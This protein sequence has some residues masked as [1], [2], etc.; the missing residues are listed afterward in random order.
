M[1]NST[2]GFTLIELLIVIAIIG[3]LAGVLVP[4]AV[5][6]RAKATDSAAA[7]V[8]RQVATAAAAVF[9]SSNS[10]PTCSY[11]KPATLITGGSQSVTVNIAIPVTNIECTKVGTSNA[12]DVT[13]TYDGGTKSSVTTTIE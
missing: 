3:L 7:T 10:F 9:I 13:V 8:S 11:T 4:I 6:A 12:L 2:T 5:N 1:R